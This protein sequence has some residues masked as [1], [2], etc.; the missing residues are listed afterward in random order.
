MKNGQKRIARVHSMDK[1]SDVALV[2]LEESDDELP[3]AALGSS[4]K[5]RAGEFVVS[6][7]SP[8]MLQDSV[9]FGIV[10]AV[11]RHATELGVA[12]TR[13]E[14]IQTDAAINV[15]NSGGPLVNMDGEVIGI[16]TMTIKGGEGLSFAIPIDTAAQVVKQLM[17]RGRV[18]RPYIGLKM[19]NVVDG[20]PTGGKRKK[21]AKEDMFNIKEPRV[22]VLD[23][24]KGSPAQIAGLQR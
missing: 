11:A 21:G 20:V 15:G 7:G 10:S 5:L 12:N 14:F 16:N 18:V 6:I 1:L 4:S 23:V 3:V 22:M 8:M 2:K 19:A 9:S 17:A 13:S 24:V